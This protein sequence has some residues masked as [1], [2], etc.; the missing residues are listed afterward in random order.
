M[1]CAEQAV[2]SGQRAAGGGLASGPTGC[3]AEDYSHERT[4]TNEPL[5]CTL[6]SRLPCMEL[7]SEAWGGP[8]RPGWGGCPGPGGTVVAGTRKGVGG[9]QWVAPEV[10]TRPQEQGA[11]G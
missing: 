5:S 9:K 4:L 11:S 8:W 10:S 6:R 7:V 3:G 1:V 2:G